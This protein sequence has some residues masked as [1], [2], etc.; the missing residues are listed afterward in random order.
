MRTLDDSII[1]QAQE[2]TARWGFLTRDLFFKF[3][4][5][6]QRS[7]KFEYWNRLVGTGLFVK[8]KS[9]SE[10]LFLSR[11]SRS[12][13]AGESRPSRF[14]V[15]IDHDAIVADVLLTLEQLDL[16]REYWLEDELMRDPPLAYRVL[17]ADK[18]YRIP[19]LV[20]D[21]KTP[22]GGQVRC[23]LE[24]EKTLKTSARYERMALAYGDYDHINLV[25]F[26]CESSYTE[27]IIKRS[28]SASLGGG[29]R[30]VP[31][32]FLYEDF[33]KS[34]LSA[35]VRFADKEFI[36][37]KMLQLVTQQPIQNLNSKADL[38]R[39]AVRFRNSKAEEVG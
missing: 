25:L 26:G 22:T 16:V 7:Q 17:G 23:V 9:N 33:L 30:V 29:Q 12:L 24:I 6:K 8:S 15:F 4:C 10:V 5:E 28:F 36:V 35:K 20:F 18:V 21:L 1:K 38:N 37:E 34:A 39:T 19:D 31:G 14:H 13:F 32:T 27:S 11:K 2:F 3:F